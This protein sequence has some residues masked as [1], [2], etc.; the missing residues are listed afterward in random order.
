MYWPQCQFLLYVGVKTERRGF[1]WIVVIS[2][3]KPYFVNGFRVGADSVRMRIWSGLFWMSIGNGAES[4]QKRNKF[5]GCY[6]CMQ[7]IQYRVSNARNNNTIINKRPIIIIMC[8]S[9]KQ[10]EYIMSIM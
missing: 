9:A 2:Y 3:P 6:V 1:R 8:L 4:V 10:H 5:I 7:S